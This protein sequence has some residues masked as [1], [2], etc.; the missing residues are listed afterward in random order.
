MRVTTVPRHRMTGLETTADEFVGAWAPMALQH[1]GGR[2]LARPNKN[3]DHG[4][5]AHVFLDVRYADPCPVNI[6]QNLAR[7]RR[8]W[9]DLIDAH[10]EATMP[11]S[12][13]HCEAPPSHPVDAGSSGAMARA[14]LRPHPSLT[15]SS[16]G[17]NDSITLLTA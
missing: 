16:A 7:A 8:R 12:G 9:R 10:T 11:M 6:Q 1:L 3:R 17:G 15:A 2:P 14:D 13:K 5:L 4:R